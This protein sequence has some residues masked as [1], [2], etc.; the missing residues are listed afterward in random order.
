MERHAGILPT[1][2][3]FSKPSSP[4]S[5]YALSYMAR[6]VQTPETTHRVYFQDCDLLGHLNNAR[7]LDYFLNARE[8]HTTTHYQLNMGA[9]AREQQ[10]AW[11]ITKHH[12]S[13]LKPA[14]QGVPG[15]HPAASSSTSTTPTWCSKCRCAA[16]TALRLLALLWSE[17]AY[18]A[19][20]AGTRTD[21]ANAMMDLLEQLDVDDITYDPDGFDERVKAVRQQL[22]KQRRETGA[23]RISQPPVLRC[24]K[25][26]LAAAAV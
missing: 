9:L 19:M 8:D 10:A 12:L 5:P 13:Y 2:L 1:D 24:A 20:P 23:G 18:V 26:Q 4:Y 16:K 11:V 17:M 25:K 6:L 21:H 15:A 3:C 22:K 7:Y 14:R